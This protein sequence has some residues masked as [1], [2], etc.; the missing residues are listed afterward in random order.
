MK[1]FVLIFQVFGNSVTDVVLS[2]GVLAVSYSTK[3]VKLFSFEHILQRV[4]IFCIL[5]N[6]EQAD[7][8]VNTFSKL[9]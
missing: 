5:H 6:I 8:F 3:S 9:H 7:Y 1:F 2:Q 4:G